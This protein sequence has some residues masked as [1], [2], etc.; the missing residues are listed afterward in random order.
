MGNQRFHIGID[1]G[2]TFTDVVAC[3]GEDSILALHKVPTTPQDIAR[4]IAAAL[5]ATGVPPAD[6]AEIA[7]VESLAKLPALGRPTG[8]G[9]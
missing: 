3:G 2:G 5:A 6:V 4:G 9:D 8:T 1:V 7:H